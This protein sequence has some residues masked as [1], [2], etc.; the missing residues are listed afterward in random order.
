M[1][2]KFNRTEEGSKPPE[3]VVLKPINYPVSIVLLWAK[4]IEGNQEVQVFLL[5]QGYAELFHATN[6]IFLVQES[7][8]WLMQ[9]GYAHL[10]AMI[11]T[12]EGHKNAG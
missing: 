9:N 11:N 12:C 10:M 7:R 2:E 5:E 8:D 3:R 4:A 1:W 6:A